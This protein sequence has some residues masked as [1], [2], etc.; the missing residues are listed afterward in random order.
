M[1]LEAVFVS[2]HINSQYCNNSIL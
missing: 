2:V 1:Q